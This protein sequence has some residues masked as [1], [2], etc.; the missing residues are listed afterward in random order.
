MKITLE[1]ILG[2]GPC[3]DYDTAA[4]I[5]EATDA[6]W[7]KTPLEIAELD[8]PVEDILWVL[9][10]P[11]IIP[12][13]QL[14][15]LAC[16]FADDV[17]LIFEREYPGDQRPRAAIETKRRWVNGDA[18]DDDLDASWAAAW[19]AARGASWAAAWAAS[20]G[21]AW[22]AARGAVWY[23]SWYAAGDV[24]KKQLEMVVAVL[25]K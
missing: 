18:T 20:R 16:D 22:G 14:H 2:W 11:E 15:L 25:K 13:E 23:A 6:N 19:A 4:A 17:L 3:V 10:R 8:I 9:L 24:V 1:Q 5:I 7:P 21:A 12:E